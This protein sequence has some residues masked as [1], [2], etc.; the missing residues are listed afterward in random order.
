MLKIYKMYQNI[1][2]VAGVLPKQDL[3]FRAKALRPS[4]ERKH[5][6]LMFSLLC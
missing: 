5:D 6:V 1:Q 2:N 3:T 4:S